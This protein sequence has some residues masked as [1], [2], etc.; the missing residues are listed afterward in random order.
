[1]VKFLKYMR[2]YLR[3]KVWGFSP[4][5]FMNLCS[6]REILLWDIEKDGD[7][8]RMSLSLKSFYR[9][10]S[11][12]KK[13]GT[14]VA[15]LERY[16]L[17]FLLPKLWKRKVFLAGL[18]FTLFFWM[19]SSLFIWDIRL[20]GNYQ[21]TQDSFDTF[22]K[23]QDIKIGMRKASLDI[24]KLEKEIR[25]VFTQVTWTS[26]KLSGTKLE[27]NIKENDAP[28][29]VELPVE[30]SG[31]DLVCQY[32]GVIVSMI[33]RSGV[34][35]V[36]IGDMVK[37]GD[38]LVEGSV[39]VYNEDTTIREYQYVQADAD[40]LLEHA[41]TVRESLPF[42]YIE[43][44]YTGRTKT[45]Y[46]LRVGEKKLELP[47][48]SPFLV[49]DSLIK[50]SCP[51]VFEKLGI[52]LSFGS[53]TYREYQKVECEY[54]LSQAETILSEKI[55]TFLETLEEKGVQIIEKNVKIDTSDNMWVI[56]AGLLVRELVG[57]SVTIEPEADTVSETG[58]DINE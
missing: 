35:K 29:S 22:L 40:I 34:P 41:M 52:P 24:E 13:T 7:T 8:Y 36:K 26:A 31:A 17:P 4:E 20:V 49:Y 12:V 27:I 46:Y 37:Q 53:Y 14:R 5:R 55:N 33:V 51:L 54:T 6:N 43:K 39:P 44:V 2:G 23:E 21:I 56:D 47:Q 42:D 30:T 18:V 50:E 32:D 15:I 10:K 16:G 25:R 28:I 58:E 1:M 48:N 45:K 3:I 9:L 57:S 38:I 19:V 11:I